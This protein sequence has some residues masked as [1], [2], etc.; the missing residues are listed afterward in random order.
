M[1]VFKSA[2]FLSPKTAGSIRHPSL[3]EHS[4]ASRTALSF[5]ISCHLH[6]PEPLSPDP[7]IRSSSSSGIVAN[8][9]RHNLAVSPSSASQ[10]E[11][12][13]G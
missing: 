11:A 6:F 2:V 9:L 5:S 4:Q 13:L 10:I 1:T 12:C 8:G 3:V 7:S